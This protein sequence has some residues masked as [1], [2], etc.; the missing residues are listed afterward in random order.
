M[1]NLFNPR[2]ESTFQYASPDKITVI[3]GT[4]IYDSIMEN[5]IERITYISETD[6]VDEINCYWDIECKTKENPDKQLFIQNFV[7]TY[8]VMCKDYSIK[9]SDLTVKG[10][11][12]SIAQKEMIKYLSQDDVIKLTDIL[13][14]HFA[15]KRQTFRL[16]QEIFDNNINIDS[17][18]FAELCHAKDNEKEQEIMKEYYSGFDSIA[19]KEEL[20]KILDNDYLN[21]YPE[22]ENEI[23]ESLITE[24]S[25]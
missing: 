15:N 19:S 4:K 14:E 20:K 2:D 22:L 1:N 8:L 7:K 12:Y 23:Y 6:W 21:L 24:L 10:Y 5:G 17:Y 3:D 9:M 18:L 11:N 25:L 16:K 13:L